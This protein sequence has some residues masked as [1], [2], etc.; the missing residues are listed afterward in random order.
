MHLF[1][2]ESPSSLNIIHCG[3]FREHLRPYD[4]VVRRAFLGCHAISDSLPQEIATDERKSFARS[5]RIHVKPWSHLQSHKVRF[6]ICW[7]AIDE[8]SIAMLLGAR[9]SKSLVYSIGHWLLILDAAWLGIMS[10]VFLS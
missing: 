1:E 9:R 8:E 10:G 5:V 7:L 4:L 3:S 2:I 6:I